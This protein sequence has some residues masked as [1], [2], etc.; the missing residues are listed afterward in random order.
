MLKKIKQIQKDAFKAV[1]ERDAE[2]NERTVGLLRGGSSGA[3]VGEKSYAAKCARLDQ[4]R[5]LGVQ[6]A[7]TDAE[8][9]MFSAGLGHE[10]FLEGQFRASGIEFRGPEYFEKHPYRVPVPRD[11]KPDLMW[12]G[13]PDFELK[14]DG[15]WVGVEA[16]ALVS[17]FSVMKQKSADWPYMRHLVQ[18]A[19]YMLMLNRPNWLIAIGHYFYAQP[20]PANKIPPQVNWYELRVNE[21]GELE[22]ENEKHEIQP[23]PFGIQHVKDYYLDIAD[24]N[25][26]KVLA[27]RPTEKEMGMRPYNRCNYCPMKNSCNKYDTQQMTFEEWLEQLKLGGSKK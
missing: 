2:A 1:S 25:E 12:G 11:G 10:V 3:L 20:N 14:I 23:L 27:L 26:R 6:K 19:A 17:N 24:R 9:V 5:M 22:V 7:V 15:Q 21:A 8:R 18:A 16:K 13:R 4:A